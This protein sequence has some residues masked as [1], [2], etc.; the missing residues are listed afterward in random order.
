MAGRLTLRGRL[1]TIFQPHGWSFEAVRGPL[2]L[3]AT[4]WERRAARWTDLIVCVSEGERRRGESSGI[5]APFTVV[6]NGVDLDA[7]AASAAEERAE[8]RSRLGL[9]EGPVA[10]CVGRL[11]EAK[12]QDVLVRAWPSVRARVPQ[13]RLLL[14]GGGPDEAE[15]RRHAGVGV[16]LVGPR[17]DVRDWLVAADVVA[18]PSRWDGMSLVLLEA[19]A[20]G[21]AVV[22]TDVPGAREAMG[23]GAGAI[24]AVKY[25][26]ALADAIATRLLDRRLADAEGA[27]ARDRVERLYN[28]R[29]TNARMAAVYADVL[30]RRGDPDTAP[31]DAAARPAA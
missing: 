15:L 3:A 8:A 24:V 1:P 2:R 5:S 27:A 17:D 30:K 19:L 23:D 13:A 4:A 11:C 9:D 12:G 10:V 28:L 21:R 22:A 6:P 26:D 25:G 18:V 7:F 29:A 16:E 14:V 31:G 20:C